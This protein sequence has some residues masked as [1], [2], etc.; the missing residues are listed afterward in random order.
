MR[1]NNYTLREKIEKLEF[2]LNL[3]ALFDSHIVGIGSW[4]AIPEAQNDEQE[5]R[6]VERENN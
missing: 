5:K 4:H 2:V 6:K 3:R 1:V